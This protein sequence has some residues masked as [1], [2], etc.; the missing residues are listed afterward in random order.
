VS[1][2]VLVAQ[3]DAVVHELPVPSYVYG[4]TAFVVLM[5]LL[6]VAFAFRSVGSRHR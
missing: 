4:I 2:A 5:A 6:G 3:G 1:A